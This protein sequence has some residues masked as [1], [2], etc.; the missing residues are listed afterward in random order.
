[1]SSFFQKLFG[2]EHREMVEEDKKVRKQM[3]KDTQAVTEAFYKSFLFPFPVGKS[4][5]LK[6]T[7]DG[8]EVLGGNKHILDMQKEALPLASLELLVTEVN[9]NPM[10]PKSS[11]DVDDEGTGALLLLGAGYFLLKVLI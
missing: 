5:G 4:E 11:T 8:K 10:M 2:G 1:M 7:M 9:E 3:A 6:I